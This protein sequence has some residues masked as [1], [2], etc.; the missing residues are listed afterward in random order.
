MAQTVR[1]R[2]GAGGKED[3]GVG[4]PAATPAKA[5]YEGDA[6]ASAAAADGQDDWLERNERYIPW[7]VF[8]LSA[9][10]RYYRLH[11]PPGECPAPPGAEG[12]RF[13]MAVRSRECENGGPLRRRP[14]L[15]AVLSASVPSCRRRI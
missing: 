11:E 14:V 9:F 1:R 8:A 3:A 5:V 2:G 12:Q 15:I 4:S 6:V 10:I 13:V 7:V